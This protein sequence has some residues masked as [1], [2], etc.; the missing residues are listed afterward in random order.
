METAA[1]GVV[2][3]R[4]SVEGL[5]RGLFSIGSTGGHCGLTSLSEGVLYEMAFMFKNT[6][7]TTLPHD[8]VAPAYILVEPNR[9]CRWH[10]H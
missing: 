3:E 8:R 5:G 10:P 9:G 7:G 1:I 4:T 2:V 6:A